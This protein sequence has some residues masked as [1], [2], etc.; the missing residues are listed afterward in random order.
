[1]R[2]PGSSAPAQR[3]RLRL[4]AAAAAIL[5]LAFGTAVY[6]TR[7]AFSASTQSTGDNISAAPDWV[8][9]TVSVSSIGKTAGGKPGYI[10]AGGTIY[11]YASVTDS[12][13]PASGTSTVSASASSIVQGGSNIALTA[14]SYT[15][16]GVT[17]NYRSA[18]Q[19]AKS[20]LNEGSQSYSITSTDAAGDSG[21][22][23]GYTVTVD[24]TAPSASDIQAANTSGGTAGKAEQGD[25]ITFTYSEST[26]DPYS[27]L[28]SWS[29]TSTNVYVRINDGGSSNDTLQVFDSG[30][31]LQLP[32]GTVDLGRKD[33]VSASVTFGGSTPSTMVQSGAAI[34]V[35]LGSRNGSAS[36][37]GTAASTGTMSW[38]PSS[39]ATDDAGNVCS[40]AARNETGSGDKEF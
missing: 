21:T 8:A 24:N 37:V 19:T 18:S 17:Y 9:P 22:Q 4:L 25:S 6:G 40:T 16:G 27:I 12:G 11:V 33:Y 5:A 14:G 26:M 2:T 34:T 39:S 30:N 10:K 15:V 7:A 28:S 23:S 13:N 32:L 36:N 20:N 29:G 38:T 31:S 35:T 1:M 3:G